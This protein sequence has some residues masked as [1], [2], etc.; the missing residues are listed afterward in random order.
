[1]AWG[2][3]L[4]AGLLTAQLAGRG[5]GR[6]RA[7]P[8]T[9]RQLELSPVLLATIDTQLSLRETART[10]AVDTLMVSWSDTGR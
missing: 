3:L 8:R 1:V 2:L 6:G 4:G 9:H 5:P 7:A 10:M